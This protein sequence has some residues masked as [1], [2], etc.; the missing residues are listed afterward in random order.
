MNGGEISGTTVIAE[1][2]PRNGIAIR[3]TAYAIGSAIAV[4]S[5]VAAS[6]E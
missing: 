3:A 4:A 2:S 5:N 6:P 1:I